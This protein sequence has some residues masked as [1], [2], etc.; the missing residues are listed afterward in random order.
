MSEPRY[1]TEQETE[2]V[3]D[4]LSTWRVVTA[5]ILSALAATQPLSALD[6]TFQDAK[7]DASKAPEE[8]REMLW[9]KMLS[10]ELTARS[11][12]AAEVAR[13]RD[14]RTRGD[15]EQIPPLD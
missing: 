6:K 7:I 2:T 13:V 4:L 10:G 3:V 1:P 5:G 14:L 11:F 12:Q 8:T 9:E 15:I